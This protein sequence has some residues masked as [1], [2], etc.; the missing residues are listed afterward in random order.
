MIKDC[1]IILVC[2]SCGATF[3]VDAYKLWPDELRKKAEENGWVT[4]WSK[5][6]DLCPE[7]AERR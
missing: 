2:D 6:C 4:K 1:E 3:C 5:D 7:C